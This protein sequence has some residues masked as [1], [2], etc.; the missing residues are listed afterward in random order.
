MNDRTSEFPCTSTP[1]ATRRGGFTLVELLVVIGIIAILISIL[2]PMLNLANEAA[3]QTKCASNLRQLV[4]VSLIYANDNREY[5]PPANYHFITQNKHRWH[6]T[7][8]ANDEPFV[9][10]HGPLLKYLPDERIRA[11][12][13]FRF[14]SEATAFERNCGGYGYNNGYLGSRINWPESAS[15]VL[16]LPEYERQVVNTPARLLQVKRHTETIAFTDTAIAN[17]WLIEYSFVEPPLATWGSNNS[18][19]LHFRHRGKAA[20]AWLDGH[21]TFERL[22]WTPPLN[23]YDALNKPNHL[24]WFGPKDNTLFDCQ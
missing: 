4:T 8:N 20:V 5:L 7:R 9:P 12:P 18:P 16:P 13:S 14:T 3:R 22:E 11:C 24:G 1:R 10:N 15:V 23:V 19:T 21:V 17:P 6:G 2:L